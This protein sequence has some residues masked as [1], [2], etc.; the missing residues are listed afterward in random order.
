MDK[1]VETYDLARPNQEEIES[2]NRPITTKKV[3]IS[4]FKSLLTEKIPEINGFTG[5]YYQTFKEE[6]TIIFIKLSQTYFF[7]HTHGI[8][9]TP[10]QGWNPHHSC[11]QSHSGDNA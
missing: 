1:F 9:K 11:N 2:L 5:K 4:N 8:Q 7:C 10:G 3:C 6:L